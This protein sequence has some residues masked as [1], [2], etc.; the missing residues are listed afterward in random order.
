MT[1]QIVKSPLTERWYVVTRY[2]TPKP[3]IIVAQKKYDVTDQ[4]E[5]I[6]KKHGKKRAEM[7]IKKAESSK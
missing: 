2:S 7:A 6:L 5:S 3:G 1:P 4:I